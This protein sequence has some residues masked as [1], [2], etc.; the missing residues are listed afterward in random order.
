M[1]MR[2]HRIIWSLVVGLVASLGILGTAHAQEGLLP[3]APVHTRPALI[4][5]ACASWGADRVDCFI[6]G[7]N[8]RMYHTWSDMASSGDAR[9]FAPWLEEPGAPPAGFDLRGGMG[10]TAWGPAGL[11]SWPST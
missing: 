9:D 8:G 5:P 2:T 10:V 3:E 7:N 4:N 1:A 11:T 6:V